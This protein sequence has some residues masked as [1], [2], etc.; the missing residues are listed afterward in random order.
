MRTYVL[1]FCNKFDD[2]EEEEDYSDDDDNDDDDQWNI[3]NFCNSLEQ[4]I[5]QYIFH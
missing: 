1:I 5:R 3:Y 4:L 2:G